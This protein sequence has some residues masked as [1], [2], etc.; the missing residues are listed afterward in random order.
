MSVKENFEKTRIE[1]DSSIFEHKKYY[2]GFLALPIVMVIIAGIMGLIAVIAADMDTGIKIVSI[3][4]VIILTIVGVFLVTCLLS[5]IRILIY[6]IERLNKTTAMIAEKLGCEID[7]VKPFEST[8]TTVQK[9]VT[10]VEKKTT[11]TVSTKA[12]EKIMCPSCGTMNK[13][14]RET[15]VQCGKTLVRE[16]DKTF[17]TILCE[18][19]GAKVKST[20]EKCF[21]CGAVIKK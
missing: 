12:D 9:P 20:D 16:A 15:C 4:G 17:V 5:V 3:I 11:P 21:N 14:T 2:S 6:H 7:E 1:A 10:Q 13:N 8:T 19:C 18:V